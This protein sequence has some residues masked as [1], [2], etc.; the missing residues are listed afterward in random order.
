MGRLIRLDRSGHTTLAEWTADDEGATES[1]VAAFRDRA[2]PRHGRLGQQRRR[3]RR[4]R[5][6][7]AARGRAG[8]PAA[9]DRR[10]LEPAD[11]A[12]GRRG[13]TVGL[14]EAARLH[15]REDASERTLRRDGRRWTAWTAWM[16][17][18]FC[19]PGGA[20]AGD[21]AAD[22][23]GRGDLP[24]PRLGDPL[25]PGPA[26]RASGRPD[27]QRAQRRDAAARGPRRRAGGARAARRSASATTSASCSPAPGWRCSAASSAPGWSASRARCWSAPA[28]GGSIAGA[29]GSPSSTSCPPAT[30]S[31]TCC[32]RCARTSSGS[33]R[34]RTSDSPARP[35]GCAATSSR[36]LAR[37]STPRGESRRERRLASPGRQ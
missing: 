20:A 3:H 31:R 32:W 21:R 29:C 34:S 13:L 35:G 16:A 2:R 14:E 12:A 7:A 10:R 4:G 1:A 22:L 11:R 30:G 37:R 33:R 23:P 18:V 25:D 6:R 26:R 28:G 27:R 5:A 8:G 17:I 9:A 15:W 36:A 19:A 24:R